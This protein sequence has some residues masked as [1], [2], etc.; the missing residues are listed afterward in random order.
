MTIFYFIGTENLHFVQ[1]GIEKIDFE[2]LYKMD[3][4][5]C[6]LFVSG[7]FALGVMVIQTFEFKV[8]SLSRVPVVSVL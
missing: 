8:T 7:H 5:P 6:P 2:D 4:S 1:M 3:K